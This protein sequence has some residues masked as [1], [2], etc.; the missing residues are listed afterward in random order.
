MTPAGQGH[1]AVGGVTLFELTPRSV[2]FVLR[3]ARRERMQ[4]LLAVCASHDAA[5]QRV[6]K[7][8][9]FSVVA[10]EEQ[11]H[12]PAALCKRRVRWVDG[13]RERHGALQLYV[14]SL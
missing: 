6:L 10:A 2:K 4:E 12:G 11:L 14:T 8:H 1:V 9:G 7:R 13:M 5:T 3:Q